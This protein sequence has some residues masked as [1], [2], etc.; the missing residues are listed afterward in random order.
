MRVLVGCEE[1]GVVRRA[2][3]ARGH[4]AWSCDLLPPADGQTNA[5]HQCDVRELLTPGLWDLA[6]FF[7][8]CRYL[9]VSGLHW[10]NRTPGRRHKTDEALEFVQLLLDA[11]IERIALENPIGAIS[12]HIRKP[13]QIIQPWQFGHPESKQTGL[14][15]RNLPL[16]TPTNI[17]TPSRFQ[18]NGRPRWDNQ[19]GTG[20]NKLGPSPDRARIRG[21]TYAG[22]GDAMADQ[23]GS[24]SS[25]S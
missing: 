13:D 4:D 2:F 16:L 23:W 14:W 19:T 24:L 6:I 5:H 22:I 10:N 21:T 8:E 12:K 18:E 11:P 1:S 7:P 15:L 20:Q 17:L 25:G 9:C 3:R